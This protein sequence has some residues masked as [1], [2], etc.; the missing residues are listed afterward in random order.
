MLLIIAIVEIYWNS[1]STIDNKCSNT[2]VVDVVVATNTTTHFVCRV[3]VVDS[4]I[5]TQAQVRT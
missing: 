2:P 4:R 1:I 5:N 3:Q